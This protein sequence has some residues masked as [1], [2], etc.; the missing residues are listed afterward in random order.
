MLKIKSDQFCIKHKEINLLKKKSLN[1][2]NTKIL[3]HNLSN[4]Q[5]QIRIFYFHKNEML[6]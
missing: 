5:K 1:I 6:N 2:L 4:N 3:I